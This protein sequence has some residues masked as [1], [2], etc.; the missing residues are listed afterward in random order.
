MSVHIGRLSN[1]FLDEIEVAKTAG[2]KDREGLVLCQDYAQIITSDDTIA[3]QA[4]YKQMITERNDPEFQARKREVQA[5]KQR[6]NAFDKKKAFNDAKAVK[7]AEKI[8]AKTAEKNRVA[9]LSPEHNKAANANEKKMKATE[10]K[11]CKKEAKNRI[12]SHERKALKNARVLLSSS[13]RV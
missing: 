12:E 9:L 13:D 1:A 11:A 10:E 3:K 4:S 6:V 8:A 5:A 2:A 7:D